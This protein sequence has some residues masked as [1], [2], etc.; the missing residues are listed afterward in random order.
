MDLLTWQTVAT[1]A[2]AGTSLSELTYGVTDEH[3]LPNTSY[4]R[5]RQTD[6]DGT[7]VAFDVVSVTFEEGVV[8]GLFPNPASDQLTVL[9]NGMDGATNIRIIDALGRTVPVPISRYEGRAVLDISI[10][11]P[12]GY[13]VMLES[14]ESVFTQRLLV[15]R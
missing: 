1:V 15:Q 2:G 6:V 9:F 12:G 8:M 3:P 10:M 4:Y 5:L 11:R 14:G 7:S 13:V